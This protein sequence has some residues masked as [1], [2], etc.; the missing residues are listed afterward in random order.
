MATSLVTGV[1]H[2]ALKVSDLDAS[3]TWYTDA[4]GLEEFVPEPSGRFVGMRS[5]T[6][7]SIALFA[8]GER[9]TSGALDH[10]AFAVTDLE[11][12]TAWVDH[13][14]ALGVP[15]EGIKANPRGQSVDL[16]DPDGNNIELISESQKRGLAMPSRHRGGDGA[17]Q[18][19][20]GAAG[21][22]ASRGG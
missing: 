11:T 19:R 6:G 20:R 8:G 1:S 13:L 10:V 9:G 5:A 12:L 22:R 7:F 4:L 17:H 2:L 3:V 18:R 15:H 14:T 21:V 16:F